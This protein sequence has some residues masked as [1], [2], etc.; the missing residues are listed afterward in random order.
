MAF[1]TASAGGY[2][3]Y[4]T[5]KNSVIDEVELQATYQAETIKALLSAYLSNNL[6]A[7]RALAGLKEIQKAIISPD[8]IALREANLVLDNFNESF[9]TSV[10]YL[11]DQKGN[12]LA[13][14]N[15]NDSVS[16]VGKNYSFRPYFQ[17]A[18]GGNP[19]TYMALGVTSKK[20]G[21]YYSYP[22]YETT[23]KR[24]IGV[25][26][27]KTSADATE[28]ELL[29]TLSSTP[30]TYKLISGPHGVIFMSD[31]KKFLYRL[32]WK[33]TAGERM[34]IS[35]LKQFGKGP[36]EWAG[37]EKR[38]KNRV[39]D[40]SGR[41]YLMFQKEIKA[42]PGWKVVHLS[43][44]KTISERV[45]APFVRIVGYITLIFCALIGFSVFLLY[46]SAKSDITN[47]LKAEEAMGVSQ[48]RLSQIINFLPDATMVIDIEGKVIAW[49]RAIED[50]TGITSENM[51]GKG[52]YE[53][54]VPFYGKRRPVLIDMVGQ[55]NCEIEKEYEY[56]KRD[57]ESLVSETHDA[58][59]K[60]GGFLWNKAS[61][62]YDNDGK[63]IGAIES[64]RDITEKKVAELALQSSEEKY[65]TILESMEDGYFET[66]IRGNLTFFNDSL[67]KILGYSKDE[68]MGMNNRQYTDEEN[69]KSVYQTFNRVYRTGKAE[70][71]FCWTIIG[72]DGSQKIVEA[73]VSLKWDSERVPIGFRGIVRDIT[74][75]QRLET[76]LQH[77]QRM[78]S[79]GTLAGG[80]SHNFNNIL[81]GIMGNASLM[82]METDA[83]HPNHKRLM[84]I[85][86]LVKSGS[87]LTAQLLGYAREGNYE[88]RP[89]NLN[90]LVYET[91]DT[92]GITKKEITVHQELS[93]Q[94][95][96]IKADQ[97]QI[98]QV[99]LNL[100]VNAA[101]AMP[102][103]GD[104]FL[105][106]YNV[107]D[108]DIAGK[109]YSVKPGNYVLLTVT[110][111][112][113]G[114]DEETK[115]RI[116]EPFFTTKG[117]A[118]G[119]GL[120]MA[121][122]YG[123]IKS[124]GGYIDVYSKKGEGTVFGIYL[125]ATEKKLEEKKAL[126]DVIV[127]GKETV[128]LVDDEEMVLYSG[129]DMLKY[130][131]YE[132]LLAKNGQEALELYRKNQHKIDMIL[133]DLIMPVMSGGET[134]D[135]MKE[136]NPKIKVLLSS[137]YSIEGEG[138]EMLKRGC[139]AFIQKPFKIEQLSQKIRE[140]LD[141]K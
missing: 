52:N 65:R 9:G 28:R 76:Q 104:L 93:E 139:D 4:S 62:L 125:P 47:R 86:K 46:R 130:L 31:H 57:G 114:M 25:V 135:R 17:K 58:L 19:S 39:F 21:I 6:N 20:R 99:L 133:L 3:Y 41:E 112:G 138:K 45:S 108:R 75:K 81:M 124:H 131:G 14:S 51:L 59:V 29:H 61:L 120:G 80:I 103:G 18:I 11:M 137:G 110:D 71:G 27:L 83:D 34:K 88:V 56:I 42:L 12:T 1:L 35:E 16:F 109:P 77:A 107:S 134:F 132:V 10:S 68:L 105:K 30:G 37:F 26:I 129:G 136:M 5:L 82:R 2:L 64:I 94:A 24:P 121:S 100:Y 36:W 55:M 128:L 101:D 73:S 43:N 117:L 22:V 85:E 63:V 69:A 96:G 90:K 7:A 127:K 54:A 122:V 70:K 50:L 74:E 115:A 87:R 89:I 44:L 49:N 92:F 15:R 102:N 98:E 97:G 72:K 119:T 13:S 116:F 67:C 48:Q 84:N 53:Y 79:I 78:E 40:Q 66:D 60:P 8:E 91:S 140:I 111:T 118:S 126:P 38:D 113:A 33:I 141:K 95:Y 106:T 23:E 32:L 123:I